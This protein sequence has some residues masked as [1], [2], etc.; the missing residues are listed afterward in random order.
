MATAAVAQPTQGASSAAGP[1]SAAAVFKRLHPEQY[2]TRFL[3]EGYRPDGRRIGAWRDVS[4]NVGSIGTA[5]GSALVRMG[6]TT[7]VCGVKAEIAEPTGAAPNDGFVVPNID[8]PALCS[9]RFKPGPPPE[10]AQTFSNWLN[11]L[12]VSSRTL[13]PSSLVIAPGKAA[14]V[15]YIDV[16][17]INYDGNAYDAAVLA[18]MAALKNTRLP[19]AT[20]NE[21]TLKTT[22]D[23][24]ETYP[25][26]LG[27]IPLTCSF[28]IFQSTYLLPDPTAFESDLL[29]TTITIALD[30]RG[31]G[32]GVRHEG[33]GGTSGRSGASVLDEAWEAAAAHVGEL[34]AVLDAQE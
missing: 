4:V 10:E 12:I 16:A 32:C 7:M 18:V 22:C 11:D 9:P 1:S 20:F 17:C 25:L 14:W 21:E 15:I 26:P 5:N 13:P 8:L 2:L 19:K 30:E 3:N 6:E 24:S 23:A 27:R 29:P 28:G 34:R 31:R 33:L